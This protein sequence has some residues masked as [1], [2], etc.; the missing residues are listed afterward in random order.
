M[1]WH[2]S[3]NPL[4]W[5]F[6]FIFVIQ[7]TLI[8][9]KW[10]KIPTILAYI[11]LG[12]FLSNSSSRIFQ[13]EQMDW[14]NG[15]SQFGLFY[16]MFLSGLEI[17]LSLFRFDSKTSFK[18]NPLFLG[19]VVFMG[20]LCMAFLLSLRINYMDR[21][22]KWW[23]IMLILLTTSLGIVMP[24]LK[25]CGLIKSY[26]GQVLLTSA[27]LA[28]L[29]TMLVLSIIAG[30]YHSGFT[31]RQAAI[32]LA[33]PLIIV[34]YQFISRLR[35]TKLW[36]RDIRRNSAVKLQGVLALLGLLAVF[37]DFTGAEPIL[38]SF[39]G[40][41]LLSVFLSE[42]N[43]QFKQLLESVG[44]G[45]IIPIFFV[46][47]GFQFKLSEFLSS[48]KAL[49][50]VPLLLTTAFTVKLLPMISIAPIFGLKRAL[51]GGFLLSARM[52][53]IVVAASIGMK[54][55]VIPSEIQDAVLIV[56][57]LTCLISPLIF[58]FSHKEAL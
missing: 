9:Y 8:K 51:A 30:S 38:G 55:G 42:E 57:I 39:L 31:L 40:G 35:K 3:L 1:H 13:V 32:G 44:Y 52:T 43:N 26:Y 14:M 16:L 34:G 11:L 24:T 49:G 53:L 10:I 6:I 58:I 21:T 46:M 5:L 36:V 22:M 56:A 4:F 33:L 45:F 25:D 54:L 48:P 37:T 18:S 47:V 28:D 27:I 20:C 19:F 7:M 15:L 2:G 50:W 17:D 29:V 23:M 12:M 41:L